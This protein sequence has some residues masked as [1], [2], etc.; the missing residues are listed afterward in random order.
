MGWVAMLTWA[1]I[2]LLNLPGH[3]DAVPT[4]SVAD[5]S[6]CPDHSTLLSGTLQSVYSF[7]DPLTGLLHDKRLFLDHGSADSPPAGILPDLPDWQLAP[8]QF[9]NLKVEF[10]SG[11]PLTL[12]HGLKLTYVATAGSKF[13]YLAIPA[14]MNLDAPRISGLKIR[15]RASRPNAPLEVKLECADGRQQI[16]DAVFGTGT[17][18]WRELTLPTPV[19]CDLTRVNVLTFAASDAKLPGVLGEVVWEIDHAAF[20]VEPAEI[21]KAHTPP[22]TCEGTYRPLPCRGIATNVDNVGYGLAALAVAACLRRPVN[23]PGFDAPE[24]A[25]LRALDTLESWPKWG[26]ESPG[27]AFQGR[28]GFPWTWFSPVNGLPPRDLLNVFALDQAHL[29]SGLQVV[30]QAAGSPACE[31]DPRFREMIRVKARAL[32]LG[33]DWRLLVR[34]GD[35]AIEWRVRPDGSGCSGLCGTEGARGNE[36]ILRTFQSVAS[37]AVAAAHFAKLSCEVTAVAGGHAWYKTFN[38]QP[39][40]DPT[41]CSATFVQQAPLIFLD[42]SRLPKSPTLKIHDHVESVT[43]LMRAHG[44]D[45]PQLRGWSDCQLPDG[46]DYK[47]ACAIPASVVTPQAAILGLEFVPQAAQSLC[48]FHKAG[49]DRPYAL[50]GTERNRGMRDSYSLETRSVGNAVFL[51]LDQARNALALFNVLYPNF[52]NTGLPVVRALFA[53][54]AGASEAY[55]TLRKMTVCDDAPALTIATNAASYKT[56]DSMTIAAEVNNPGL[57][58]TVDLYIGALL[59]DGD[60]VVVFTESGSTPVVGRLASPATLR[61]TMAGVDLTSPFVLSKAALFAHRWSGNEPPGRYVLFL[62]AVRPGALLDN[63]INPGDVVLLTTGVVC[64]SP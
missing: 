8:D 62:A 2:G 47:A 11:E 61:P 46:T 44:L 31:L 54:D 9:Q 20:T 26:G 53:A 51:G 22:L 3:T 55:E 41:R 10:I 6:S 28:T 43:E 50:G 42:G 32:R 34:D 48:E 40:E 15:G 16:W 52:G 4:M 24:Q 25:I 39:C 1:L 12:D 38:E 45:L 37:K 29:A 56:A 64:F 36:S 33:M 30:E 18:D 13:G 14:N 17:F 5:A 35:L 27:T 57:A 21:G 60:T 23:V 58:I 19:P 63:V 59:P 49:V 7:I